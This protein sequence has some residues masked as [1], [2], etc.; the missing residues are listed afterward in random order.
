MIFIPVFAIGVATLVEHFQSSR[1]H[2]REVSQQLNV[3]RSQLNEE[4]V[5]RVRQDLE[6]VAQ[7]PFIV[8]AFD[9]ENT[10]DISDAM[11]AMRCA[12]TASDAS[13]IYLLNDEGTVVAGTPYNGGKTLVGNNYSFRPYFKKVVESGRP[14]FYAALGVTT[15]K[16]GIYVS[17][18]VKSGADV[19]GVL[20]AK[21]RLDRIDR[22]LMDC[23]TPLA[24][25]SPDGVVFASNHKNWLYK[26]VL[27]IT[28]Q[29][30][31]ELRRSRQFGVQSLSPLGYDFS[32]HEL[33][34]DGDT[35]H[36]E[37]IPVISDR[38]SLKGLFLPPRF[39]FVMF[40]SAAFL[41]WFVIVVTSYGYC[42]YFKLRAS[43]QRYDEL[44]E[45]SRTFAW[46]VNADGIYT[47]VSHVAA[48]VIGYRPEELIGRLHFFDLHPEE[49]RAEIIRKAFQVFEK[50]EVFSDYENA[51]QTKDGRVIWVSTNGIP[52]LDSSGK[53]RGYRGSDTDIT[54][55]KTAELERQRSLETLKNIFE[56]MPVGL[57]VV[58]KDKVVRQVNSTALDMMNYESK[59]DVVGHQC[60]NLLCPAEKGR[61]PILDLGE[62]DD[63]DERSLLCAGG[64]Q[65]P[66]LKTA[67]PIKLDGEEVLLEAFVDITDRKEAEETLL[68]SK[69][70]IETLNENLELQVAISKDLRNQSEAANRAKSKF[71]ANMSHEIRTPMTA[72]L[73]YTDMLL[74]DNEIDMTPVQRNEAIETIKRN[75]Q[76]LLQLI[77]DI[78]DLSKIEA[79]KA[80]T[81]RVLFSPATILREV[82]SMMHV[83]AQTKNLSLKVEQIG[84]IPAEIHSD[85]TRLRQILINLIGNAIKFTEKG[86]VRIV[87]QLI[88]SADD[89]HC[90]QF[91]V[92]DT[93]I[94]MSQRQIAKLFQPFTQADTSTTRKYG[95]TGL[96]LIISKR[97]AEMLGGDIKV[98]SIPGRQSIFTLTVET[99]P[100]DGT[101][102]VDLALEE[103]AFNRQ[104]AKAIVEEPVKLECRILLAEDVLVNQL[105]IARM[106]EKV[107]ASVT[108]VE[109]GS[110][111]CR[112]ALAAVEDNNPFDVILMDMQMPV[113]D[114]YTAT[115]KLREV[116]YGGP[117]IA[118]TAH[119]MTGDEKKCL[120]VGCN[121]YATKPVD[122][123]KLIKKI[124]RCLDMSVK[125]AP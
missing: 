124:A 61:C 80:D 13:L 68:R 7:M 116:N 49:G 42:F 95:G 43:K 117:I 28:N 30:I 67:V 85:P 55:R 106:L 33:N 115:R 88:S 50:K 35:F 118:L 46:E 29:R 23:K 26:T 22:S 12:L 89:S 4:N 102:L 6:A 79:G 98:T 58:G 122:R 45:Q 51:I 125:P 17:V 47:Y 57:L 81:E 104:Q 101:Q 14:A 112:N 97:L 37:S 24:L 109:N 15:G 123:R 73:G 3:L 2:A 63:H 86:T 53:L 38:W 120:E 36:V 1:E 111:A 19:V 9:A 21:L 70:E 52:L 113:M 40:A 39:N 94:G 31:G 8:G 75:G 72:I 77:N 34:L 69:K 96:G 5:A 114:G 82:I 121:D 48:K 11:V 119:A 84:P 108:A 105:L 20:V 103:T 110:D 16:R 18:P 91:E 56:S 54:H 60:H 41:M 32:S 62:D 65:I 64:R 83:P 66:I 76:H 74:S 78:L 71:L 27:P 90:L 99:G 92:V 87:T 25:V 107:G 100:L 59:D 93:G 44:A 10:R